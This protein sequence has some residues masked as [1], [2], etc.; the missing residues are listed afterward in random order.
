M[1]DQATG[2]RLQ[3]TGRGRERARLSPVT[4]YLLLALAGC[5]P[6]TPAEHTRNLRGGLDVG[7]ASCRLYVLSP[8]LPRDAKLDTFCPGII[9]TKES[10]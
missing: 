9:T 4:C 5:R 8:Q 7:I 2:Y 10:P 6:P 1:S 3:V